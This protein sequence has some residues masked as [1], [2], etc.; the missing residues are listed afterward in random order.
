M[1]VRE[2]PIS[3]V[4]PYEGN[5]RT[6]PSEAVD[7]VAASIREFGFRQPI[8][9]DADGVIIAGH[10]RL[11]AAQK[12]GL[13]KVPVVVAEECTPRRMT[14]TLHLLDADYV[15]LARYGHFRRAI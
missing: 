8:V 14:E 13:E 7:R 12:L 6:I 2:W 5:P 3:D 4:R 9:V 15:E 10:T 11:K 1:E